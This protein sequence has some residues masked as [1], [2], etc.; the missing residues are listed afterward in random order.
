MNKFARLIWITVGVLVVGMGIFLSQP[1][2]RYQRARCGETL[3]LLGNAIRT[4][5]ADQQGELPHQLTILSNELDNPAFLVCPGSGHEPGSFANADSW[6]DYTFIDWS[7]VLG[8]NPVPGDYPIAY[9]RFMSNHCSHG[10]NVL[11]VDGFVRW[12]PQAEWLRNFAAEHP[13]FKLR[14]PE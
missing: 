10:I 8:T 1:L 6:T 12:D 14:I 4:Y 5:K 9:D 13:K 3:K 7:V 11:T 2:Y